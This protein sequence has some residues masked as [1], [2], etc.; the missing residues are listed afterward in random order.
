MV[1]GLVVALLAACGVTALVL[2]VEGAR[3]REPV[4]GHLWVVGAL[5]ALL[6]LGAVVAV[7]GLVQGGQIEGSAGVFLAYLVGTLLVLPVTV[8]WGLGEPSRWTLVVLAVAALVVGVLVLRLQQI[9]VG[10]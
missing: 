1:D 3:G 10:A 6:V 2:G 5:E 7:V 4:V 9:W 8:L